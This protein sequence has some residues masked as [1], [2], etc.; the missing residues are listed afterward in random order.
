MS[1]YKPYKTL[2]ARGLLC[3]EPVLKTNEAIRSI[4][5]GQILEVQADDPAAKS[6]ITSWARRTGHELL[7]VTEQDGLLTFLL[8]RK[9]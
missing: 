2:D 5:V 3:P 8:R 1:S 7:S 6:D 4:E 9:K